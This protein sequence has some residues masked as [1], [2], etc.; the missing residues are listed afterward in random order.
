MWRDMEMLVGMWAEM[1]IP[2]DEAVHIL[3]E[4]LADVKPTS[5]T[6]SVREAR[7]RV[8]LA[9][10]LSELDLPPF[11]KSAMDG[12][13]VLL[14]DEREEYRLLETV[15]AGKVGKQQLVPGTTVKVMTGAPVPAGTGRVIVVEHAEEYGDVVRVHTPGGPPHICRQAEDV[16][17]GDVVLPAGTSLDA[18][19]I[20]NLIACGITDVTVAQRVKLAIINTGEEIVDSRSLLEPG[21]VMNVNGPLLVGLAEEHGLVVVSEQSVADDRQAI[22]QALRTGLAQ[23][24]VVVTSGGVSAGD[25]DF[26]VEALGDVALKL[27]FPQVAVKP[28]K[29][30]VYA[31]EQGKVVFGLPGNPVSVYVMFH[32]LV[33]PAVARLSGAKYER[34]ELRLRLG[35]EF[36]R[37]KTER[38]EYVPCRLTNEGKVEAVEYHG[39]AHLT[40]LTQADGFFVVPLGTGAIAAGDEVIFLPLG[41]CAK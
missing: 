10:Q 38:T 23:A 26:V 22:A 1:I 21:K 9:D 29:R 3:D 7:G 25:F 15:A 17:R 35:T 34:R 41:R 30:T 2:L 31:S 20:A 4:T 19:D 16:R 27:H 32:L 33:L 24:D 18:L 40:A 6:V 12:Y 37:R 28:G 13:A 14:D 39:S 36:K 8:L 11:D 5:E